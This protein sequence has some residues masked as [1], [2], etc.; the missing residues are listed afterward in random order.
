MTHRSQSS[1][2]IYIYITAI[3]SLPCQLQKNFLHWIDGL[4]MPITRFCNRTQRLCYDGFSSPLICKGS[5]F[6]ARNSFEVDRRLTA[7][8]ASL[9]LDSSSLPKGSKANYKTM[10]LQGLKFCQV[11]AVLLFLLM[12][13]A[14]LVGPFP[15]TRPPPA[16]WLQMSTAPRELPLT[17]AP[18]PGAISPGSMWHGVLQAPWCSA[19]SSPLSSTFL[20]G[21]GFSTNGKNGPSTHCLSC[22][23]P[24][25]ACLWALC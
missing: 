21:W 22:F 18:E 8:A 6:H 17:D 3:A 4:G 24:S 13:L 5:G 19:W 2:Y 9:V 10:V 11:G 16:T 14:I 20:R 23:R 7:H 25:S 15:N 1:T 12:A